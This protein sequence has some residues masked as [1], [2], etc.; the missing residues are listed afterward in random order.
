MGIPIIYSLGRAY[1]SEV[2][3]GVRILMPKG[4]GTNRGFRPG[5]GREGLETLRLTMSAGTAKAVPIV[6]QGQDICVLLK[7]TKRVKIYYRRN[8]LC[9]SGRIS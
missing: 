7:R 1:I 9:V 6:G 3:N 5:V 8:V 4:L 2:G